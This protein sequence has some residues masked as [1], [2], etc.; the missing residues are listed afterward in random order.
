[1]T[2]NNLLLS[3]CAKH[4]RASG[5]KKKRRESGDDLKR[6]RRFIQGFFGKES[7]LGNVDP[8]SPMNSI[9]T[10]LKWCLWKDECSQDLAKT[11]LT[12]SLT[13]GRMKALVQAPNGLSG[14]PTAC[15]IWMHLRLLA[16]PTAPLCS[17]LRVE[18]PIL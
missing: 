1:M 12:L 3:T 8:V 10:L 9:C 15:D 17:G 5:K 6:L 14:P 7:T 16:P 18:R 4:L 13:W 11:L 2:K